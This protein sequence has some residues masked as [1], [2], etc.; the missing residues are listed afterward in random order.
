MDRT[1]SQLFDIFTSAN[2]SW[3]EVMFSPLFVCLSVCL[4]VC[5]QDYGKSC[6][7]IVFK[8]CTKITHDNSKRPLNFERSRSKVKVNVTQKV[9]NA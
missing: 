2:D 1:F 5:K 3:T 8:L 7:P 9:K 6:T 4:Y